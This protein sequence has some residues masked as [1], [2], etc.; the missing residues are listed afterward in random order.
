MIKDHRGDDWPKVTLGIFS[1][2]DNG[3]NIQR[4][5][6]RNPVALVFLKVFFRG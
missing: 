1:T 6:C 5:S 2:I 4:V 3:R